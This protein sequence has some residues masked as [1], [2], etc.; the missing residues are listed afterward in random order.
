MR[1]LSRLLSIMLFTVVVAMLA[2]S[3]ISNF[4][5]VAQGFFAPFS[6]VSGN[7]MNPALQ[8]NDAVVI[9]ASSQDELSVGDVVLFN[10]PD[11]PQKEIVHRI[12]AFQEEEGSLYVATRGDANPVADP[13][14]TPISRIQGK[15][16]MT[17]PKLG[18]FLSFVRTPPGFI[19]CIF[20]PLGL[21][22]L[23]LLMRH[24]LDQAEPEKGVL[25]KEII[26]SH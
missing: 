20:C 23:Y 4:L 9:T 13:F 24:Y 19:I 1:R 11:N 26:H 2:F 18:I 10:D 22:V 3:L 8:N 17:I 14:L 25:A 21:M 12:V 5:V 7:S 6:I 15:V 16:S